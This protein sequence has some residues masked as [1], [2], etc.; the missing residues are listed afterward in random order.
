[1]NHGNFWGNGKEPDVGGCLSSRK[2]QEPDVMGD[3]EKLGRNKR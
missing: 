1:M 3:S 2:S